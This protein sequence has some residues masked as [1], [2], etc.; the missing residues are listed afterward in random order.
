MQH[1]QINL[2]LIV[3]LG[4]VCVFMTFNLIILYRNS[5]YL[6]D[7]AADS[8]VSI[9]ASDNIRISPSIIPTK[10]E[11]GTV[12]VCS[13]EDYSRTV[14]QL[15][16]NSRVKYEYIIP[17]GSIFVLE[18]NTRLD[19]GSDFSFRFSLDGSESA[20]YDVNEIF[21]LAEETNAQIR[22]EIENTVVDFLDSGSR[23]FDTANISIVTVVESVVERGG[24]YYALCSRTIDGVTVTGN[25]AVCT[26][27][28]GKVTA[29]E[30]TWS[31]LTPG[32]SYTAQLSDLFNIL[33][34]VRKEICAVSGDSEKTVTIESVE[35]CY[36][37]Y[38]Y[39]EK[40][41]FCLI[42]CWQISTDTC[43]T[44]IYNALD[45]TLYTK[46]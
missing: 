44:F 5:A 10:R 40:E 16:G 20:L 6:P 17:D 13:S 36:S 15:L 38:Y 32:Q 27:S 18:N 35:Q 21:D 8:I 23:K 29:A 14:A 22:G 28:D 24:I 12:Y 25:R 9:L 42:P 1:R 33:F 31:F 30:G 7:E 19:F 3:L 45:S 37:I 11:R 4:A 46:N 41:D 39:G 26:V 34:N 43:G 2:F